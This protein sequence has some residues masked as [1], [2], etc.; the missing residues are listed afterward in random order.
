M[1]TGKKLSDGIFGVTDVNG[2][3][4]FKIIGKSLSLHGRRI[5][6]DAAGN[7][8]LTFQKKLTSPR[9][10][11]LCFRGD[12]TDYRHYL[13]TVKQSNG[14]Q[15]KTL[16]DVFLASNRNQDV[17]DFKVRGNWLEKRC[18]VFAGESTATAAEMNKNHNVLTLCGEDAYI[19]KVYP[20]VDC[21]FIVALMVILNEIYEV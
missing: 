21:A 5:L 6:V 15:Y 3:L 11:W 4:M 14:A 9:K 13:F 2:N 20:N 8:I 12:N 19:V 17:A 18:A 16:L 10:T 7:R 1:F